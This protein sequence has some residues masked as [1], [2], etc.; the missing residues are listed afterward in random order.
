MF[1]QEAAAR[2]PLIAAGAASMDTDA[3]TAVVSATGLFGGCLLV[4]SMTV[5][6]SR[7]LLKSF[8]VTLAMSVRG[9][10]MTSAMADGGGKNLQNNL[11]EKLDRWSSSIAAPLDRVF[12]AARTDILAMRSRI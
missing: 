1:T 9:M 3:A 10:G 8:V 2:T 7:S 11:M 6:S 12:A 4:P 5:S